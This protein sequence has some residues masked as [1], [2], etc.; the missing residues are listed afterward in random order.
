MVERGCGAGLLIGIDQF[1]TE[2]GGLFP[3]EL[4]ILAARTSAGKTALAM[5]IAER[6]AASGRLVYLASLEMSPASLAMRSLCG[7]A[8]V[9]GLQLRT[10]RLNPD[11][12]KRLAV[13]ANQYAARAL[14]IDRRP[15]LRVFD[16]FRTARRLMRD[17]LALVIVDYLQL[18]TPDNERDNRERQVAKMTFS[19]KAMARELKIPVLVLSQLNRQ[20]EQQDRPGLVNLR[21]SGAIEQD[22]DMVL[23]IHR[24]RDGIVDRVKNSVNKLEDIRRP[25]PAELILEKN[26]SG[27]TATYKL[28]WD[29]RY[30][31]FTSWETQRQAF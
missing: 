27:P 30:T 26:R 10:G 15:G 1:D 14:R 28:D 31:R 11:E 29:A 12:A 5:Q 8:G 4:S 19:L 2:I 13:A 6:I 23:F 24:P 21:E 7:M 3:S 20:T 17:G 9:D 22:A 18:L 25:W 16:V